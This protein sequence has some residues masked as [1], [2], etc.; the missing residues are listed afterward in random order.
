M[1]HRDNSIHQSSAPDSF[2]VSL[3]ESNRRIDENIFEFNNSCSTTDCTGLIPSAPVR[4]GAIE[5]Y[6]AVYPFLPPQYALDPE[7]K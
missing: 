2:S 1:C 7:E 4:E 3:D 6:E 5:S